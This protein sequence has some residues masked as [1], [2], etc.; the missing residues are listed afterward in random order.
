M[1]VTNPI[2]IT[3]TPGRWQADAVEYTIDFFQRS[4][5]FA[6]TIR[7][8]GNQYLHHLRQGQPPVLTF[9]YEVL[10]DGRHMDPP[11]N[12]YL[13]AI[14]DR[15]SPSGRRADFKEKRRNASLVSGSVAPN[16]R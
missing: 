9:D 3:G 2:Q 5:L 14:R 7:Q 15:R 12:Y 13:A 4:I 6:D 16:V 11:T 10:L 8:R 1:S